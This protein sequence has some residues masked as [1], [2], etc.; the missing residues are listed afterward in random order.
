[1]TARECSTACYQRFDEA[2]F[3]AF[4]GETATSEPFRPPPP[5]GEQAT[6]GA[7]EVSEEITV[8]GDRPV[9]TLPLEPWMWGEV[10]FPWLPRPT[11]PEGPPTPG[12]QLTPCE[13]KTEEC[14]QLELDLALYE[15]S[16]ARSPNPELR[17]SLQEK[18]RTVRKQLRACRIQAAEV[19]S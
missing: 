9:D 15:R 11:L 10:N 1:L 13:I 5:P 17:R 8:Y 6:D 14:R 12:D 19:C 18:I 7:A 4:A 3:K 16:L 2:N